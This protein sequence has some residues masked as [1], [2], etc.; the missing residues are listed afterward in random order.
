[1][2]TYIIQ[3]AVDAPIYVMHVVTHETRN[4]DGA[5]EAVYRE[6]STWGPFYNREEAERL[7]QGDVEYATKAQITTGKDLEVK[8]TL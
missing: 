1:M 8:L 4:E 7:V 5:V 2:K 3:K 6:V